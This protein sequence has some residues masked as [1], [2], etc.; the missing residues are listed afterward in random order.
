MSNV[1]TRAVETDETP[2]T[3]DRSSD[4]PVGSAAVTDTRYHV[5]GSGWSGLGGAVIV[6][7]VEGGAGEG[8]SA[9][10]TTSDVSTAEV[11]DPRTSDPKSSDIRRGARTL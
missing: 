6:V 5:A 1:P 11:H 2:S 4:R 9:T 10:A 8:V 7:V 3:V